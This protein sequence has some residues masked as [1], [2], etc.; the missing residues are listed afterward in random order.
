MLK[1]LDHYG[2]RGKNLKLFESYFN[3]RKQ[4]VK[5]DNFSSE[6]KN[7]PQCGIVQGSRLS[8]IF[9]T[10]YTNE[11]TL[12]HKFMNNV[13]FKKITNLNFKIYKN[14]DHLTVNFVDD[15]TNVICFNDQNQIKDYLTNLYTLLHCY[16]NISKLKIN[17]DKTSLLITSKPKFH[18]VMKNFY[19]N[20]MTFKISPTNMI[21]ILGANITSDLKFNTHI[22]K[23]ASACHN[24]I[25]QLRTLTKFTNFKTRLSFLN[26]YVIGKINYIL[27]LYLH[28]N[29]ENKNKLFKILKTAAR[30]AIGNYCFKKSIVY[31][32]KKC[33]WQNLNNMI[34]SSSLNF[35]HK[36]IVEKVPEALTENFKNL[37]TRRNVVNIYTCYRPKLKNLK[38]FII[39]KG[40]SL[41]NTLPKN[42]KTSN[43]KKF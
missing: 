42:L 21:K 28:T 18:K 38:E 39:Y 1:K 34:I 40:L 43:T 5:I 3:N 6:I 16:Y 41:Y 23:L 29:L 27:P 13:W 30:A 7:S 20:S 14:V 2:I 24:R 32:L 11:V 10:L 37:H 36:I 12:L 25:F 33:N 19:F 15:S 17:P 9:Y 35:I 22:G 4:F 31:I 26:S 8:S